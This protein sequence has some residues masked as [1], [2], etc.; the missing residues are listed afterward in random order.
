MTVHIVSQKA[1]VALSRTCFYINKVKDCRLPPN[2]ELE[3]LELCGR[4]HKLAKS[5]E[6]NNL[7]YKEMKED[8]CQ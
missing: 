6:Q 4:L 7:N 2:V 8:K 1:M 3:V 5:C